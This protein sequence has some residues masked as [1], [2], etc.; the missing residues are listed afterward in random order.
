MYR[1]SFIFFL[2]DWFRNVVHQI[3]KDVDSL[4]PIS[5]RHHLNKCVGNNVISQK[6][7]M[8]KLRK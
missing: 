2:T 8:F 1:K 5:R 3:L 7:P 6:K 4:S